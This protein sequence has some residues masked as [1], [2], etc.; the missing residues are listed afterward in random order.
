MTLVTRY[1]LI[2]VTRA[3]VNGLYVNFRHMRHVRATVQSGAVIR[4]ARLGGVGGSG[5]VHPEWR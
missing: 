5:A 3:R 1:L 4:S 2:A